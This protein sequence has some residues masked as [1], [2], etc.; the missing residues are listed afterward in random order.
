MTRTDLA[1]AGQEHLAD[2]I[3]RLAGASRERLVAEVE[4]L[5]L[6]LVRSLVDRFVHGDEHHELGEIEPPDVIQ[7][8][9]GPQDAARDARAREAGEA[10]L[11]AGEVAL[12]LLA[13]GQGTRLGFDGPKGDFPFAP[14]T[15]RTLFAHHAAKVGALRERYDTELPWYLMTSDENDAPTR[16][17]FEGNDW[18]GLEPGSVGF[19]R[20][21][22]LPAV[23]RESGRILLTA[24][25]RIALSPDGH[26]GLLTAMRA[27]GILG[28]LRERGIRTIFT[29][30][31]DNPLARV[32]RPELVGHHRLAGAEMSSV[33]VRKLHA[34]ERM[35]VVARQDGRTVLVEYSDLPDELARA[36]DTNGELV[37]WA[38]SIAVHCVELD[39]VERLTEG[40]GR[41]PL[42][43]A[44]K[45]VG[46]VDDRG[47]P[48]APTEPNAVKFESFLFDALP[49]ARGTVTLEADRADEFSPIKNAD[50]DD[51]PETSRRDLRRL[52]GRWLAAAGVEVPVGP[53][54]E[55]AHEIEIDPR[56]ALDAAQVAGSIDPGFRLD[57]P[58]V[59]GP[60]AGAAS[61]ARP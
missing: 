38:G 13:G 18:F 34:G 58:T 8:P 47:A 55:P 48:V 52:Y 49:S 41:L 23:D 3:D 24:P 37:Y 44:L 54:G 7:V 36:T 16:A 26:G 25:D 9:R 51:S 39:L 1:A 59:L 28:E 4:A 11:R 20:Q 61:P 57:R 10:A 40:G 30:Q 29:F 17:S 5:D 21:G 53:D 2:A 43:R 27:N 46:H 33:V 19:F 42:H 50:G 15:G 32:A 60:D 12:V 45:K 22:T 31:V 35:G 6:D 14:L 56:F